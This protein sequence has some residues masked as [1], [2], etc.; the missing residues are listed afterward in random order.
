MYVGGKTKTVFEIEQ[1]KISI[2]Y[3]KLKSTKK[4]KLYWIF[5]ENETNRPNGKSYGDKVNV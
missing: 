3:V 1:T 5:L 2:T 4:L